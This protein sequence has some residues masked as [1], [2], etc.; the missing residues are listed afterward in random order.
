MHQT[1]VSV[2]QQLPPPP[3]YDRQSVLKLSSNFTWKNI[4]CELNPINNC[5]SHHNLIGKTNYTISL[6]F[7]IQ[8]NNNTVILVI[9][10]K[11]L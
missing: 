6:L 9:T 1:P 2:R 7:H 5:I 4:I 3:T 10:V 8:I 11:R